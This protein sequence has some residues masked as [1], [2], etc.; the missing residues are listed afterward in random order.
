MPDLAGRTVLVVGGGRGIERAVEVLAEAGARVLLHVDGDEER[1]TAAVLA[2]SLTGVVVLDAPART[3]ADALDVV[4]GIVAEH[5]PVSLLLTAVPPRTSP[6][7]LDVDEGEWADAIAACLKRSVGLTRA[8]ARRAVADGSPLRV[9]TFSSSSTFHSPGALQSSLNAA[10][11]SLA[12][13]AATTLA[14]HGIPVNCVVLGAAGADQGGVPA[15]DVEGAEVL[16][17]TIAHLAVD[18]DPTFTGRYVYCGGRDVGLYS[19]PLIIEST[20]VLVRLPD[21]AD[22]TAVG[23]VLTPLV[24]V[25][26]A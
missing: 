9:V 26:R 13:A 25:G 8:V 4:D 5:G 16:A 15:P 1:R 24:D 19:V 18:A 10:M 2:A 23:A 6:A 14:P 12:G 20:H 22:A 21:E 3:L 17:S 7:L 11:L